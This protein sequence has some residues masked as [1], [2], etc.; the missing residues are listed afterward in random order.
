M[1]DR[2]MKKETDLLTEADT[3]TSV[4]GCEDERIRSHIFAHSL[5]DE[6]VRVEVVGCRLQRISDA[7]LVGCQT[8]E[9]RT[10]RAPKVLAT[11]H[12]PERIRN[13]ER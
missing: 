9:V 8:P 6:P 7:D 3:R 5:V 13:A 12:V 2:A 4:E 1:S 11:M 10:S